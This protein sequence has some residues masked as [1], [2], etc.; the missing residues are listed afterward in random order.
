MPWIVDGEGGWMG[1]KVVRIGPA[2]RMSWVGRVGRF[3]VRE[4]R[5]REVSDEVGLNDWEGLKL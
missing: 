3:A 2:R 5:G 4:T 1:F